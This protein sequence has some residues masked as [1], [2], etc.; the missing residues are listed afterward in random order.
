MAT[1]VHLPPDVLDSVDKRA[2]ALK[3]SRN[4]YIV[5]ALRARLATENDRRGWPPGFFEEFGERAK[6]P[7]HL[8]EIRALQ[9]AIDRRKP[10]RKKAIHL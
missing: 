7:A 1:S 3:V 10:G 2:R 5:E 9:R 8:A 6:D 4:R